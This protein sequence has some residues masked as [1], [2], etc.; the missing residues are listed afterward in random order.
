MVARSR[1]AGVVTSVL[2][3]S[4]VGRV[5]TRSSKVVKGTSVRKGGRRT[6][7]PAASVGRSN[8]GTICRDARSRPGTRFT[9]FGQ[10]ADG[11]R[12]ILRP[13]LPAAAVPRV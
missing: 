4:F 8:N 11:S 10:L 13:G 6:S 2:P 5:A 3:A 12:S 9:P 7:R 1:W